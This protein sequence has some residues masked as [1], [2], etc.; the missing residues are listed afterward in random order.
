MMQV[1]MKLNSIKEILTGAPN[2]TQQHNN[3]PP[4]NSHIDCDGV[5]LDN[6]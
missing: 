3:A 4:T 1:T 6:V 5:L 2:G